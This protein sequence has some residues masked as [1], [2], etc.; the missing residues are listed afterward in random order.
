VYYGTPQ[1]HH[2]VMAGPPPPS[3]MY[4]HRRTGKK[5]DF[6]GADSIDEWVENVSDRSDDDSDDDDALR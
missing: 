6:A 2:Q 5:L 4:Y 1:Q 3:M